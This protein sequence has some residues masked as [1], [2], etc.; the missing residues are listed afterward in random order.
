MQMSCRVMHM[1]FQV[2]QNDVDISTACET[3]SFRLA[4][5]WALCTISMAIR[6][7]VFTQP[8]KERLI[9][10]SGLFLKLWK[11]LEFFVTEWFSATYWAYLLTIVCIFLK[12]I[13]IHHPYLLFSRPREREIYI[14]FTAMTWPTTPRINGIWLG[15]IVTFKMLNDSLLKSNGV[16]EVDIC[17]SLVSLRCRVLMGWHRTRHILSSCLIHK[18]MW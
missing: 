12:G 9:W 16:L 14:F 1:P 15:N 11:V 7:L 6:L 2:I 18:W 3:S 13:S 17:T 8:F 4:F 5:L 10:G